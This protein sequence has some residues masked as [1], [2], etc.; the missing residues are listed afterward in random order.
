MRKYVVAVVAVLALAF[1][2]VAAAHVWTASPR[3]T[4][5]KVPS[6]T[7][8][9]GD[10]V[11]IFGRIRSGRAFCKRNR[12]VS[13]FRV[14]SGPDRFVRR[15]ITDREGEYRF[16]LRLRRD[17]AFYTRIG[18][19]VHTSYGHRHVCRSD[20]SRTIRINVS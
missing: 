3:L 17:R 20:R 1:A 14:R 15:D 6:G 2:A 16:I 10:R 11:V 18:R 13:L 9:R 19:L 7:I 12:V 8:D 4:I 5:G